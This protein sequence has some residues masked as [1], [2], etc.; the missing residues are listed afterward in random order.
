MPYNKVE[1]KINLYCEF[2]LDNQQIKPLTYGDYDLVDYRKCIN[3]ILPLDF[4]IKARTYLFRK[5]A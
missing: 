1:E 3:E 4:D 2:V 5:I